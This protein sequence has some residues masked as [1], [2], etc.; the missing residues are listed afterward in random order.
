MAGKNWCAL[1][2]MAFIKRKRHEKINRFLKGKEVLI[3]YICKKGIF[4]FNWR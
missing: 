2:G 1:K 3:N 4:N